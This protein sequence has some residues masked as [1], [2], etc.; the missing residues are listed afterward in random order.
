M[1]SPRILLCGDVFGRINQ[2]FKRVSTVSKS[3]G[4]FDALFCVGQFFPEE[5]ENLNELMDYI[6][7]KSQIPIPTYFIGDYG[8][9]AA[10][11]LSIAST[12]LENR[13]FKIDGLKICNN[14]YCLKG[15]GLSIAYLSGKHPSETQ[16]FGAYSQDDIDALR[17]WAEEP[18]IVDLFLTNEWPS[19]VSKRADVSDAPAEVTDPAGSDPTI[20][21]LV[22]EIKPRYHIAGTKGVYYAREPYSNTESSHVTRFLGLAPVGNKDKQKFIH[23]ISPTPAST[24]SSTEIC[25]KPANTTLS[26]YAV[27][28]GTTQAKR[29]NSIDSDTQFW[30]Y[31]VSQKRQRQ[32]NG[33]TE[34][35]CFKFLSSGSCLQGEKC[36]FQHDMDGR[37]QF[38]RGVCFDFLTK[39]KCERGPDCSF[40]HN[41]VDLT[42]NIS[43]GK[44]RS[45]K[46]GRSKECWFCLSSPNVESHLI[47]CIGENF[48]CALAKG[49]LIEDHALIIPIEHSG[50]VFEV[51]SEVELE[52]ER[53]K[54]ALKMYFKNQ[55]KEVVFFEWVSKHNSHTNIQAIPIPLPKASV[56]RGF[57]CLAAKKLGFEFLEINSTKNYSEGRKSLKTQFNKDVSIFYVELPDGTILSHSVEDNEKFLVQ[58]GR[59][60]LAGLLNVP[61]KAD[62][63][64]CKLSKEEEMKMTEAF[65]K[66]FEIFDP[67]R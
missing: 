45:E 47:L 31:D 41:L 51:E 25:M 39:G 1:A 48:Y 55:G 5:E 2:L 57:F 32:G 36:N 40:K 56:V 12:H 17:A 4:P 13:G 60:V 16:K 24:M 29:P 27:E 54:K 21:E 65:K 20:S 59:E 11:L 62:W 49:P 67:T 58:F 33:K 8:V 6:E 26:P 10:K 44:Q 22:A 7:G 3:T 30:R 66:R 42:E 15:S 46:T 38:M 28:A 37:E 9:G 52:L 63:K 23:A 50:N 35:L 14:L 34:K 43:H 61:D 19:N 53:F 64:S 18:R